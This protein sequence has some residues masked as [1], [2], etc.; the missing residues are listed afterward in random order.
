M[1]SQILYAI[2]L[3][4]VVTMVTPKKVRVFISALLALLVVIFIAF[5]ML[6][7]REPMVSVPSVGDQKAYELPYNDYQALLAL[8]SMP[9]VIKAPVAEELSKLGKAI[10]TV[11]D[12]NIEQLKSLELLQG[13][14][15]FSS[16][17][18]GIILRHVPATVR[19][20]KL[21][22]SYQGLE[23]AVLPYH[24]ELMAKSKSLETK[25]RVL[26]AIRNEVFKDES[27]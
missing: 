10:L 18:L 14:G 3:W 1:L 2:I 6:K 22:P 8:P 24:D 13:F 15:E 27:K 21:V 25:S 5:L 12:L 17:R 4:L 23:F 19:E 9:G 26:E 7:P 16:G 20:G 11:K